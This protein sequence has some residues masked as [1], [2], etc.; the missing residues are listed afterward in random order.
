MELTIRA[1][2][3]EAADSLRSALEVAGDFELSEVEEAAFGV[4]AGAGDAPALAAA[5]SLWLQ[6]QPPGSELTVETSTQVLT[7]HAGDPR[8]AIALTEA[9]IREGRTAEQ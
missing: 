3:A 5:L 2:E 7:A 9:V 1:D 4:V 8:A 6:H